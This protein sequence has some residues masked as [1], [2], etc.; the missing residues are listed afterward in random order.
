MRTALAL[1]FAVALAGCVKPVTADTVE[2]AWEQCE[3][4]GLPD[5]RLLQCSAVIA[6]PGTTP[7]RR[8]AALI[9]R[10][11]IRSNAGD[12]GRA[13][14]DF[15]RAMRLDRANPQAFFERAIVHQARGAYDDALRDFDAALALQPGLQPAIERRAQTVEQKAEAY[16]AELVQLNALI[17]ESPTDADL[18]NNRCWLRA[19]NGGDLDLALADCNAS[20]I[21]S[22]NDPN[23]L[24][25]RGLV[26]YLRGDYAA[27]LA[28][29]EAAFALEPDNGHFLHGRGL[30]RHGLGMATES[31]ADL[32][33]ADEL[34]PGIARLYATYG[35]P[36]P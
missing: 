7:E 23:V 30:A 16:E 2:L 27:A 9:V 25:S 14:A 22:P 4:A 3:G 26:H 11:A 18:L 32:A 12:Y 34:R 8:A 13:L 17:E 6:F 33:A 28:D 19:T 1:A 20:L 31:A 24:D 29:Y 5:F 10:G 21:A 36:T 15:G 35:V